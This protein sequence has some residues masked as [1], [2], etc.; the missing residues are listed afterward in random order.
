MPLACLDLGLDFYYG[1]G[2]R[3]NP[4]RVPPLPWTL[5][6]AL[7]LNVENIAGLW[8]D[9]PPNLA[10]RIDPNKRKNDA[11]TLTLMPFLLDLNF[12]LFLIDMYLLF[13]APEAN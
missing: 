5:T 8:K 13:G 1:G 10:S 2:A 9:L 12:L 4:V 3:H 6:D 7:I 11:K